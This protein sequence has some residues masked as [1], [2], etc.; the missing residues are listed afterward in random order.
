MEHPEKEHTENNGGVQD[1]DGLV[2]DIGGGIG[3][4]HPLEDAVDKDIHRLGQHGVNRHH[5]EPLHDGHPGKVLQ[6]RGEFHYS[7]TAS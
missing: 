2:I 5:H 1:V 3:R 4:G 7:L 6:K